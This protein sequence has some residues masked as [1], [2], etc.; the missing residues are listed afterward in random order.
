MG[1]VVCK[2]L[3]QLAD[4]L[5][6]KTI[7]IRGKNVFT[8]PTIK[9]LIK[10]L[11]IKENIFI[12]DKEISSNPEKYYIEDVE[13]CKLSPDDITDY[14]ESFTI[15]LARVS[16]PQI[17][18]ELAEKQDCEYISLYPLIEQ[19][20]EFMTYDKAIGLF[21]HPVAFDENE[22]SR[23]HTYV[24]QIAYMHNFGIL[25]VSEIVDKRILDWECGFGLF[26]RIFVALGAK[27][28]VASDTF[29]DAKAIKNELFNNVTFVNK[30]I[31]QLDCEPFDIIFGNT[32]TEHLQNLV[33]AFDTCK[34][35]LNDNGFLVVCHDNYF[36]PL[37]HHDS[38]FLGYDNRICKP[39]APRCYDYKDCT[40]SS[41]FR[42]N[43]PLVR[44]CVIHLIR[45]SAIND[46]SD[47]D[48]ESCSY[49]RRSIPW[50]HIIFQNEFNAVFP[51]SFNTGQSGSF[52][53]KVNPF[54]L[55]QLIIEA[56]FEIEELSKSYCDNQIPP[57]LLNNSDY[58]V[59]AED[60][61]TWIVNVRAV[62]SCD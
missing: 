30:P 49:Y 56:G 17:E 58:N 28:V 14:K 9:H 5:K 44:N 6:G 55:K 46:N 38:V 54:M 41:E 13:V 31:E 22:L 29:L 10:T 12:V 4:K 42:K 35:L 60:L 53:N 61:T 15:I 2:T 8:V 20:D 24:N 25:N 34:R 51:K 21:N 26:S 16:Y 40:I 39:I 45:N 37:G 7:F 3:D 11:N 18:A 32:V 50:A 33:S 48:C 47:N 59:T 52:L 43:L 57:I 23:Y 1:N 27:E 19:S 62:K 36:Q